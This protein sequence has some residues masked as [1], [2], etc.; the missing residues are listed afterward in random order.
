[1]ECKTSDHSISKN[2]IYLVF[3]YLSLRDPLVYGATG[4]SWDRP[5]DRKEKRDFTDRDVD[6]PDYHY[7]FRTVHSVRVLI[8]NLI[9]RSP[10]AR[11]ANT[12]QIGATFER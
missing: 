7:L 9:S 11:L 8:W 10:Q 3:N 2:K 4:V 6:R 12:P 1:M 5:G